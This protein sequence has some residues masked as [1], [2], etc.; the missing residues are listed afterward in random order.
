MIQSK[1]ELTCETHVIV[2]PAQLWEAF[3]DLHN[4]LPRILPGFI[5][6]S[7]LLEGNGNVGTIREIK[8]SLAVPGQS[9]TKERIDVLDDEGRTCIFSM[10]D[11][12]VM[13]NFSSFKTTWQFVPSK[14]SD[15]G[16]GT[17]V[18]WKI[19][20]VPVGEHWSVD[21]FK[22]SA[23]LLIKQIE[24]HLIATGDYTQSTEAK[25][26]SALFS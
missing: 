26:R 1:E 17:E 21:K 10:L 8:F 13:E 16:E 22:D 7:K 4:L 24:G 25:L 20:Y 6:S 9:Y 5:E 11:G 12:E 3:K 14:G 23:I 18:K 2:P 19:E 15:G